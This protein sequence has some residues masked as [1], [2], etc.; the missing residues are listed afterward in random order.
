MIKTGKPPAEP[1]VYLFLLRR[2]VLSRVIRINMENSNQ[3]GVYV[4]VSEVFLG[5]PGDIGTFRSLLLNLSRTDTLI[6]CARLNL[7]VSANA[8]CVDSLDAQQFGLNQFFTSN[9]IEAINAFARNHGGAKKV[10]VFFRG[11]ILELFR[12]VALLCTDR[13]GDGTTYED[14]HIR[15]TFAQVALIASDVWANRIFRHK[16]SLDGGIQVARKRALGP[17]RKSVEATTAAPELTQSLGRGWSLFNSYLPKYYQ[18]FDAD[19]FSVTEISVEQYFVAFAAVV[20]SFMNPRNNTGIFNIR[21]LQKHSLYGDIFSRYFALECQYPDELAQ[22]LWSSI[23]HRVNQYEDAPIAYYRQLRDRPILRAEDGRG[24]IFDPIFYSEKVSI[25]P[26]FHILKS[27]KCVS[28]D[29]FNAFGHAFE[30][31]VLD[32]LTRMFASSGILAKRFSK[33]ILTSDSAGNCIEVDAMLNNVSELVLFEVK[34]G[35]I[36]ENAVLCDDYE[37]LL[38]SLRNKYSATSNSKGRVKLKGVGQLA[39]AAKS[40]AADKW[41]GI[42]D[43]FRAVEFIYPVLIVHDMF[44]TAPVY[45]SFFASEFAAHLEPDSTLP[46]G[47]FVKRNMKIAPVIVMSVDDLENLETSI[48]HFGFRDLLADYSQACPDRLM[49]LHNFISFSTRYRGSMY[50]NRHLASSALEILDKCGEAVFGKKFGDQ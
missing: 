34:S 50:H 33:N 47:I 31:Y 27:P 32:I 49:S 28:D 48:E 19:F 9:E 20:T 45:G 15:R 35:L 41:A 16:Y 2:L 14:P 18:S 36:P 30:E 17:N 4:P 13:P 43:D 42:S 6:W 29:V 11:K 38:Q 25:G 3:I 46:N 7:V 23:G 26:L 44:L 21:D 24:I 12:W 1:V 10:K 22:A 8:S 5:V 39:R 37:T 40:L